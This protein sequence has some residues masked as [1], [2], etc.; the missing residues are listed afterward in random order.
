MHDQMM[1]MSRSEFRVIVSTTAAMITLKFSVS[2]YSSAIIAGADHHF[3]WFLQ[4][5]KLTAVVTC[6]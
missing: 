4:Q 3:W 5:I 2:I 6:V 1:A